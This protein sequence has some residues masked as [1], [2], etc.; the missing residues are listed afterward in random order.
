MV[1]NRLQHKGIPMIVVPVRIDL[2]P[3]VSPENAIVTAA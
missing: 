2:A 1:Q 3:R